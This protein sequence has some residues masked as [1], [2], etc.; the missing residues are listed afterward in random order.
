MKNK[1][2]YLST[3]VL[4]VVLLAGLNSCKKDPTALTLQ[5]L[6]AGD[7]DMNGAVAPLQCLLILPLLLNFP[8][9]LMLQ[10]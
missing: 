1:F 7:I 5:T 9:M 6:V 4:A 3:L 8:L 10:L 2:A